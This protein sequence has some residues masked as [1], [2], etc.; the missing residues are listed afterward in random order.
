MRALSSAP[1]ANP[2][3]VFADTNCFFGLFSWYGKL[4]PQ[5]SDTVQHFNTQK[6]TA[7]GWFLNTIE[8]KETPV[9]GMQ[10]EHCTHYN[11]ILSH[12]STLRCVQTGFSLNVFKQMKEVAKDKMSG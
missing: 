10:F 7:T 8:T 9:W 4:K 5:L 1:T 12:R 3:I 6:K 2:Y 11:T